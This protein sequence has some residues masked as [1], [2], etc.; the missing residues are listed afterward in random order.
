MSRPTIY[1]LAAQL[2]LSPSTVSRAFS[3]PEKVRPEVRE[4][5]LKAA[6]EVDYHP[7]AAARSLATGRTG[8]LGVLVPDITNPFFPPLLRSLRWMAASYGMEV[9]FIDSGEAVRSEERLVAQVRQQVDAFIMASPRSPVESLVAAAAS[10]PVTFINR[11]HPGMSA[12]YCDDDDA[13]FAA[14]GHLSALGHPRI[15]LV[16]GPQRSWSGQRRSAAVAAAAA[17]LGVEIVSVGHFEA[18]FDAGRA[19]APVVARSGARAALVFDDVMACGVIAGLAEMGFSV[20]GDFSLVGCDDV[21]FA[22]M[23]TPQLTTITVPVAQL[24]STAVDLMWARLQDPQAA[25]QVVAHRSA[26]TVR[27]TTSRWV[28]HRDR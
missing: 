11:T 26:L 25:P 3:R 24:G 19:S 28:D 14:V 2:Q 6:A 7:H 8:L 12:T 15:A 22:A 17:E 23:L 4:R 16:E 21:P 18:T 10:T 20:P 5:I 1:S 9:M 13:L 27:G